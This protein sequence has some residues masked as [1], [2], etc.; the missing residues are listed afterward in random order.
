[1]YLGSSYNPYPFTLPFSFAA[2]GAPGGCT[3]QNDCADFPPYISS[4]SRTLAFVDDPTHTSLSGEPPSMTPLGKYLAFTTSLVGVSSQSSQGSQSCGANSTYYCTP[5]FTW[6]WNSTFNGTAGGVN[7]TASINP[8]DSGSGT[9]GATTVTINGGPPPPT[10]SLPAGTYSSVQT[11]S[12]SDVTPGAVIYYTTN[13]TAPTAASAVYSGA[14]AVNSTETLEAIAVGTDS[15]QSSVTTAAYNLALPPAAQPAFS[16]AAGTYTTVQ[17]VSISDAT[18]GAIIYYTTNG[19]APTTASAVYAAA[20]PVNS[21][22]TLEAI[23]IAPDYSQSPVATAHYGIDLPAKVSETSLAVSPASGSRGTVFTL[24]AAATVNSAP[25]SS[26][27]VTFYDGPTTLGTVEVNKTSGI[28]T[29]MTASL[30]Q[31]TNEIEAKFNQDSLDLSSISNQVT[32]TVANTFATTAALSSSGT[33]GNYTLTASLTSLGAGTP[34]GTVT[35]ND[36]STKTVLGTEALSTPSTVFTGTGTLPEPSGTRDI[37]IGDVSGDGHLDIVTASYN[38]GTNWISVAFGNGDGTFAAPQPVA[39]L[40]GD[41]NGGSTVVLAD[42]NGDGKLDI[43]AG[44]WAGYGLAVF[45]NQGSGTFGPETDYALDGGYANSIATGDFNGDGNLDVVTSDPFGDSISVLLGNGDGTFQAEHA[46]ATDTS[47]EAVTVADFNNDGWLDIAVANTTGTVSIFLG[48]GDGTFQ[49]L[50]LVTVSSSGHL[51]GPKAIAAADFNGDGKVDLAVSIW[52]S[53]SVGILLGNGNGSFQAVQLVS[54]PNASPTGLAVADINR[55]GKPDLAECS[56]NGSI[57]TVLLGNGD[58]SFQVNA[59]PVNNGSG[60]VA[61]GDLNGDGLIDLATVSSVNSTAS[62]RLAQTSFAATLAN[63]TL[64]GLKTD[65][66]SA[67]YSGD[68]TFGGSTSNTL[69]LFSNSAT[70]ATPVLL[71]AGG[72]YASTQNVGITDTTSGAVVYYTTNGTMPSTSSAIYSGSITVSSSETIEAIAVATGY[73]NSAVASSTYTITTAGQTVSLTPGSLTFPAT[74]VGSTSAAQA[75]T[76]TNTSASTVTAKSFTFTGTNSGE[77]L[78]TAKTCLTSLAAGASCTLS[79]AFKPTAAGTAMASLAATD[80]APGSPQMV[81]LTGT[82]P[83]A[84]TATLT[85]SSLTFPATALGST[86]AVQ[87]ATLTNTGTTA[88]TARSFLFTGTNASEFVLTGKTCLTSLAAGASCTLSIA[89]KPAAAGTA[90][91]SLAANASASNSPQTTTLT[92]TGASLATVSFS[93]SSLTFAATNVGTTSAAQTITVTNTS[94]TTMTVQSYLFTGTNASNFLLTGKTC[95]T[96]L[97]AGAS[98]TLS[99]A[100]RP[101]AAGAATADLATT[102]SASGSPQMVSLTGTGGGMA[103]VSFLP[104]SLTF[105]GMNEGLTSMAQ[106]VT[107]TNTSTAAMTVKSFVFTGT[108]ASNFLL[109][110]KTCLTSLAAG[111]NCTLSIAFKPTAAGP[112]TATLTV[113][114]SAV[115]SPQSVPLNGTGN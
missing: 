41:N 71:L 92:G 98:C 17:T 96:S 113:T 53:Q 63:V 114:D 62:V 56:Y 45:L 26:G 36:L 69:A 21:T 44:S 78:L 18:S 68:A 57:A 7:Q 70:A 111:A 73:A 61:L 82:T 101:T 9:G 79:V 47:P 93:P 66:I 4:D 85:P 12:I 20:I 29:L 28:A 5:L 59:Y 24:Q 90:T 94:T 109:T 22:E 39:T 48:N 40:A 100:F 19:T 43:L 81:T 87:T 83:V 55:D 11:V 13:G 14:T 97:A 80:S 15:S 30:V 10:F 74:A 34:T 76:M 37:A 3:V 115:G 86:S 112:A 33:Q 6:T 72:T 106:T 75:V 54:T 91:A 77:F 32:A 110:G 67:T 58:G 23:A 16:V 102:D 108:N 35:F 2:A 64:P 89:F 107:V 25:V 8:I 105:A 88:L 31:G 46:L 1:M 65:N 50:P 104:S 95:L 84:A 99:I 42:I 51:E 60:S 49:T 27:S 52:D 38:G 103:T